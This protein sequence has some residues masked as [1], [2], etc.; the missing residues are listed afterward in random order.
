VKVSQRLRLGGGSVAILICRSL[1]CDPRKR[2]LWR[3]CGGRESAMICRA[4]LICLGPPR[5]QTTACG[6]CG[7]GAELERCFGHLVT[8]P[9]QRDP[10]P[11]T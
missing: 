7:A 2:A 6:C 11:V 1:R 8:P 5:M 10:A 9:M 4:R 3:R